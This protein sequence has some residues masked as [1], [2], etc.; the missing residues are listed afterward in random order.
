M[1]W[2]NRIFPVGKI[3]CPMLDDAF[4]FDITKF[5]KYTVSDFSEVEEA[6]G[7]ILQGRGGYAILESADNCLYPTYVTITL[8]RKPLA[9][10][11]REN[12]NS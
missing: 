11:P 9:F 1:I 5:L 12:I 2:S 10:V 3:T 7:L 8:N 4:S 6:N